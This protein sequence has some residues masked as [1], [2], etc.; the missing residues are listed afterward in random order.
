MRRLILAVLLVVLGLPGLSL[1]V[2]AAPTGLANGPLQADGSV[3]VYWTDSTIPNQWNIYLGGTLTYSPYRSQT[4]LSGTARA[5]RMF[6]FPKVSSVVLTMRALAPGALISA[7]SSAI[8]ITAVPANFSYVLNPPGMA[9]SISGTTGG[10]ADLSSTATVMAGSLTYSAGVQTGMAGSLTYSA[11]M[12]TSVYGSL[13]TSTIWGLDRTT[14]TRRAADVFGQNGSAINMNYGSIG[15]V[16]NSILYGIDLGGPA[17]PV[18]LRIFP[19]TGGTI[20]NPPGAGLG[21]MSSTFFSS[22]TTLYSVS[23]NT[24]MP[25]SL[26]TSFD[27]PVFVSPKADNLFYYTF[28]AFTTY[29]GDP[30]KTMA[31]AIVGGAGYVTAD[32]SWNMA[33]TITNTASN[34]VNISPAAAELFYP[35]YW[36]FTYGGNDPMKTLAATIVG[37]VAYNAT[38]NA[39][40][41]E[42][43]TNG[44]GIPLYV[45][46]PANV[47]STVPGAFSNFAPG[48]EYAIC[49]TCTTGARFTV[50]PP[51][52]YSQF[53][54]MPTDVTYAASVD[55]NTR[56]W[57]TPSAQTRVTIQNPKSNTQTAYFYMS[58]SETAELNTNMLHFELA[59]GDSYTITNPAA[60]WLHIWCPTGPNASYFQVFVEWDKPWIFIPQ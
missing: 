34:P 7:E 14:S 28:Q 37:S 39:L 56:L 23:P 32:N 41:V 45:T 11:S 50:N 18:P 42:H 54:G 8:T 59:A 13:T 20:L 52:G 27:T 24:P 35:T 22:G 12:F 57:I 31:A 21:V 26:T 19:L 53:V 43:V 55:F 47:L 3:S 9:I 2:V 10:M 36:A 38:D 60:T 16:T 58:M 46:G 29:L 4:Y 40:V 30:N 1:A 15:L 17:V 25:V 33:G 48:Y 51:R 6:P 44:G 5:Y 49:T